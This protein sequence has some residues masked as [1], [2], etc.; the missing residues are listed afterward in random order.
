MSR[1]QLTEMQW[2]FIQPLLSPPARTRRPRAGDRR[3]IEGIL[4]VLITSCRWQDLPRVWRADD[5]VAAIA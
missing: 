3:T 1:I 5:G 4:Y 2:A